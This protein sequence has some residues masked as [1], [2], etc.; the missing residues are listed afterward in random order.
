M[1]GS[2][3]FLGGSSQVKGVPVKGL[4][5]SLLTE[6]ASGHDLGLRLN[7]DS[8]VPLCEGGLNAVGFRILLFVLVMQVETS[9]FPRMI[10]LM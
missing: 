4:V 2:G 9:L 3:I 8:G 5:F 6:I 1:L 10:S 7:L